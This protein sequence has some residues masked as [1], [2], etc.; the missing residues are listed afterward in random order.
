MWKWPP[1]VPSGLGQVGQPLL[2]LT[3]G[4]PGT[5]F[6]HSPNYADGAQRH[7]HPGVPESETP[8]P[9]VLCTA[10][11]GTVSDSAPVGPHLLSQHT[12][13]C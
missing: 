10:G 1:S 13:T 8:A 4:R 3:E 12:N 7:P 9:T 11:P 2:P 5:G 6:S